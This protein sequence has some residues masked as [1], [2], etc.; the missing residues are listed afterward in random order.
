M[1]DRLTVEELLA[2]ELAAFP[3]IAAAGIYGS[4]A[5]Q[6]LHDD[7]DIDLLVLAATAFRW[8][9]LRDRFDELEPIVGRP[10]NFAGYS[11]SDFLGK[12]ISPYGFL[13]RILSGPMV[14]L[15]GDPRS[16]RPPH[17]SKDYVPRVARDRGIIFGARHRG[18][19]YPK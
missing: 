4:W 19:W 1:L 2:D 16:L 17:R 8:Q 7:S 15:I 10:L 5:K 6:E 9:R 13:A 3:E 18:I 11:I 12:G 14:P